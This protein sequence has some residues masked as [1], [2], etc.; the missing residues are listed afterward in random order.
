MTIKRN[1]KIKFIK[2]ELDRL[3]WI[4]TREWYSAKDV[5]GAVHPGQ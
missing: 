3:D 4:G 2:P 1:K 5:E